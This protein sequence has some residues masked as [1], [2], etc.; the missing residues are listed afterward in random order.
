MRFQTNANYTCINASKGDF[1]LKMFV[2]LLPNVCRL[3]TMFV[4]LSKMV[5]VFPIILDVFILDKSMTHFSVKQYN[6]NE[7]ETKTSK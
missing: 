5:D 6:L 2:N 3:V 7:I 1:K 4:V